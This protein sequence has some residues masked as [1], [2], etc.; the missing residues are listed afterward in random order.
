[1]KEVNKSICAMTNHRDKFFNFQRKSVCRKG[2][3]FDFVLILSY[4]K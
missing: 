1:M 4:I 2:I 3:V